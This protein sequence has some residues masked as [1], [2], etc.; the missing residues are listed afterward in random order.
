MTTADQ[1]SLTIH[2]L[3]E[4]YQKAKDQ[5]KRDLDRG[6]TMFNG[7]PEHFILTPEQVVDRNGRFVLLDALCAI[8][9]AETALLNAE[10]R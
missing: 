2:L 8:A 4:T 7:G 9:Q 1:L 5:L 10:R 3:C 6:Q